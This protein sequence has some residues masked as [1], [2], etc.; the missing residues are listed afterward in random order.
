ML[1]SKFNLRPISCQAK[2]KVLW[3]AESPCFDHCFLSG[4]RENYWFGFK[5]SCCEARGPFVETR[6]RASLQIMKEYNEACK[7]CIPSSSQSSATALWLAP[8]A[9]SMELTNIYA[10]P[11][12]LL[13]CSV[14]E[15]EA[16][17]I[18]PF[19]VI[20]SDS[21]SSINGAYFVAL[22]HSLHTDEIMR[23][24]VSCCH[25]ECRKSRRCLNLSVCFILTYTQR[26]SS[27]INLPNIGSLRGQITMNSVTQMS[28][29]ISPK[30]KRG[31]VPLLYEPGWCGIQMK[32]LG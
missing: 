25:E 26:E 11:S 27:P 7:L 9:E 32:Q 28:L 4:W 22:C 19:Y 3:S 1:I 31:G 30:V 18:I 24:V 8:V 20:F 15:W 21:F 14:N 5:W 2:E 12:V 29:I 17:M 6:R 13:L 23:T 16:A 10:S